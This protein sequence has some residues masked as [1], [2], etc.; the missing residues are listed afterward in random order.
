MTLVSLQVNWF[1]LLIVRFTNEYLPTSVL[2]FL[3]PIFRL[4]SSLRS[5]I[6]EVYPLLLSN[7]VPPCMPWNERITGLSTVFQSFPTGLWGQRKIFGPK[8]RKLEMIGWGQLYNEALHNCAVCVMS[9]LWLNQ[10][11]VDGL[12]QEVHEMSHSELP[13]KTQ[14]RLPLRWTRHNYKDRI[15]G[16]LPC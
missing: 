12:Q 9:L 2:C 10:G 16:M 5:M 6:L 8:V 14:F 11:A 7:P 1:Q 3:A 13:F 4:W 15:K